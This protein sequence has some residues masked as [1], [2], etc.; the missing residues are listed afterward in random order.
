LNKAEHGFAESSEE[1]LA[2]CKCGDD[3]ALEAL[4]RRHERPVYG[5]LYRMLGNPDDAEEA[6]ADVFVKI[7][8]SATSFRGDA[9]FTTW[10]YQVAAN[11]ARDRLRSRRGTSNLSFEEIVKNEEAFAAIGQ[12]EEN[13]EKAAL[14]A[15]E[16]GIVAAAMYTLS[17]EDRLLVTLHHLQELSC[18]EISKITGLSVNNLKVKLFRARRKLRQ[19]CTEMEKDRQKNELREDT[20]ET[21]GLQTQPTNCG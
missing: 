17:D 2:R 4:F 5:L 11:T 12:I 14:H 13:P 10:L 7:W 21:S 8:R 15:V 3:S 18:E 1:L 6:L 20:T 9:R 16:W 19:A